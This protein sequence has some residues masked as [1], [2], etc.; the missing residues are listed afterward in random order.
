MTKKKIWLKSRVPSN[1]DRLAVEMEDV[2]QIWRYRLVRCTR[3]AEYKKAWKVMFGNHE[4]RE[5]MYPYTSTC[6]N[7]FEIRC[8]VSREQ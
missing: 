2:S 7:F 6:R 1:G 4:A 5:Y 8:N 3:V